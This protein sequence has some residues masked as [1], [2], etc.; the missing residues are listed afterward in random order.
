MEKLR[1]MAFFFLVVNLF[2]ELSC[3]RH[4]SLDLKPESFSALP[5]TTSLSIPVT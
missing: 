5:G 3:F 1:Y 4:D 2:L